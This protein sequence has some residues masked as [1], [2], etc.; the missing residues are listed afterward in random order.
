MARAIIY[1]LVVA[2]LAA[3]FIYFVLA[4]F[5]G[6]T[7]DSAGGRVRSGLGL[8]IEPVL[9]PLRSVLPPVRAGALAIDLSSVIVMLV[10][11]IVLRLLGG[12]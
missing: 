2:Y 12:P 9:R 8:I 5:P 10:L 3:M 6:T 11:F 1:Y 7:S 4:W